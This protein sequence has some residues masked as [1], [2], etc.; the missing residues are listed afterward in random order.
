MKQGDCSISLKGGDCVI[1]AANI[2]LDGAVSLGGGIGSGVGVVYEH[3][4]D[5][6]GDANNQASSKVKVNV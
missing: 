5:V 2:A 1:K 6:R 3:S 4:V